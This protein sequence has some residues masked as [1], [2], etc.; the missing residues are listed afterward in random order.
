MLLALACVFRLL[1][2]PASTQGDAKKAH[3]FQAGSLC[4]CSTS[5]G[6][7]LLESLLQ[8]VL[9][10]CS[11]LT[12]LCC[13]QAVLIQLLLQAMSLI[14]A[15]NWLLDVSCCLHCGGAPATP[16]QWRPASCMVM[17]RARWQPCHHETACIGHQAAAAGHEPVACRTCTVTVDRPAEGSRTPPR[18]RANLS[19]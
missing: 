2:G 1:P 8:R 11:M 4:L 3:R 18:F 19:G 7:L 13:C 9:G 15:E 5:L 16:G 12:C 17:Q 10:A 6:L 14:P